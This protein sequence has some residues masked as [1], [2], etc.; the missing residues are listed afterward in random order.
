MILRKIIAAAAA[1]PLCI[2]CL[3]TQVFSESTEPAL[4]DISQFT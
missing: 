1:V 2:S 4:L 3:N